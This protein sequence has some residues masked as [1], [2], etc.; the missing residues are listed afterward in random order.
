MA[1]EDGYVE[2]VMDLLGPLGAVTGRRMF[3]GYGIWE[4]GDMFALLDRGS[5]LYFKVGDEARARY[6]DAG[7]EQFMTMPYWS[8]P[9]DVLEDEDRLHAWAREAIAVG[10]AT[11][12]KR[13]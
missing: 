11:S 6:A 12:K 8:V 3:G 10:H 9:V 5:T 13:R 2:Y 4:D 7:S 1:L